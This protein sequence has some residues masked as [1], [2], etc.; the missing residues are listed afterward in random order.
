M[1]TLTEIVP[2]T[3]HPTPCNLHPCR[4]V[5]SPGIARRVLDAS[6]T[7][8]EIVAAGALPT[9]CTLR[10]EIRNHAQGYL[11]YK[12][13]HLPKGPYRRPMPRV[14]WWSWGERAVAGALPT[15]YTLHEYLSRNKTPN[16]LGPL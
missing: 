3:V 12:K 7:P 6:N 5:G 1:H 10:P 15:P 8:T 16:L 13:R 2:Y 4:G 14:L 11:T 9:P